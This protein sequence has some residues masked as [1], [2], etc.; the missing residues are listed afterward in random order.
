VTLAQVAAFDPDRLVF[1]EPA[2]RAAV[3]ASPAW[4]A[5]RAVREGHAYTA[6]RLP[7]GWI[8]EPPSLNQLLGVAWLAGGD[9]A[10]LAA[11]FG[12]EVYGH[13]PTPA[14]LRAVAEIARPLSP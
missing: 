12:T 14:E 6:P 8:E 5:L 4:R 7:F 3:A 11:R 10:A 1:S 2:M 13:T 9:P